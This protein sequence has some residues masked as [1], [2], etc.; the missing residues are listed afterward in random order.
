MDPGNKKA[1]PPGRARTIAQPS[2]PAPP[3]RVNRRTWLLRAA[4]WALGL[5]TACFWIPAA[6]RARLQTQL[7]NLEAE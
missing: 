1:P 7:S 2:L 5:P 6:W 3:R 4:I